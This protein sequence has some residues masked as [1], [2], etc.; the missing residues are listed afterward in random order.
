MVGEFLRGGSVPN[1]AEAV[2]ASICRRQPQARA[3]AQGML[4]DAGA[5]A[6][7]VSVEMI[8]FSR[9]GVAVRVAAARARPL[10]FR[11]SR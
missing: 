1:R 11:S 10:G 9:A 8:P 2:P 6:A 4:V 3:M 5:M 7:P